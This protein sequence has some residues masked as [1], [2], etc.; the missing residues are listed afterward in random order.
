LRRFVIFAQRIRTLENR[1]ERLVAHQF[2]RRL[3]H[4]EIG[5]AAHVQNIA[6]CVAIGF[7]R[8]LIL[9][10]RA[11]RIFQCRLSPEHV[12][13]RDLSDVEHLLIQIELAGRECHRFLIDGNEALLFEHGV[14]SLRD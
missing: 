4:C 14:V 8:A 2:V 1:V 13:A 11:A 5:F 6:Q 9:D 7:E 3:D 10:Q 12:G